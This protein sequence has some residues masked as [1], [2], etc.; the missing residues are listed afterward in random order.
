VSLRNLQWAAA[1]FLLLPV[2]AAA[3]APRI[4]PA[5]DPSVQADTIYRLAV[6]PADHPDEAALFLLDDGVI[7]VEADGRER[8]T[9]R[10]IVQVLKQSAVEGLAEHSFSWSPDNE[11]FTLNWIRVVQPDGTVISA[12]PAQQQESDVPATM[13][14]PVYANRKV[15][16][17]SMSGVAVGTIVDF[18]YT[19]TKTKPWVPGDFYQWWGV[20]TGLSVKRSR[21]VVDAPVS[22][23]LRIE[24]RNLNFARRTE[25]ANGRQVLTWATGD[26]TRIKPEATTSAGS[27]G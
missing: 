27:R 11:E 2:S 6:D 19:T 1:A 26:L 24:E 13:G 14:A 15:I 16:R 7:V 8:R 12:G 17:A 10:Q 23:K 18:S 21:L 25:R 9:F 3:Q 5:G 20:S 4:T 22:E